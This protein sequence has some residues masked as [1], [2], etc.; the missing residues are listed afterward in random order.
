MTRAT[1]DDTGNRLFHTGVDRGMLYTGDEIPLA[2]SWSGLASVTE[3]TVGGDPSAYYLDGRKILNI[4]AG[5]NFAGTIETFAT[6]DE[7]MPCAG[8]S[9]LSPGLYATDQPRQKF[10]FSYRT[11]I[12]NDVSGPNLGYKVHVVYNATAQVSPF[13]HSTLTNDPS[14]KTIT[15]SFTTYPVAIQGF[16]PTSHFIFD[17]RKIDPAVI[18][19]LENLLYGDDDNDPKLPTIQEISAFL[20]IGLVS[21]W[22]DLTGLSDF[23]DGADIGDLGVDFNTGN[24]Y[25]DAIENNTAYWWDLTGGLDFPSE[26]AAGDWGYDSET[27]QVWKKT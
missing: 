20:G 12:G 27:G 15:G 10:H 11:L 25:A 5:E 9:R 4:P 23:P 21:T 19:A 1:W 3:A 24:L 26:A 13:T 22:W 14:P 8:W 17:T 2:V 16:R 18:T 7:F 6:P